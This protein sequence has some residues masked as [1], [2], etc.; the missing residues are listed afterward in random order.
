MHTR[1]PATLTFTGLFGLATAF[2]GL[3][4]T[5]DSDE[6][7]PDVIAS[8]IEQENGG[9]DMQDEAPMFGEAERFEQA[10][11][12]D[13]EEAYVDSMQADEVVVSMLELPD[14]VLFDTTVAWG[15]IPGNPANEAP[16]DWTGA[17]Q[18]NR[19]AILVRRTVLFEPND[20][21]LP[22]SDRQTVDFHSV[23]LPHRD[24]MRLTIIDPDPTSEEPLI[25][26]YLT[27]EG[28]VAAAPLASLIEEPH[29]LVADEY[30]N[31]MVAVAFARPVDLCEYGFLGGVWHR[32]APGR[33]ILLGRVVDGQGE[34][35][36]YMRGLYGRRS[37]GEQVFF[38]KYIN[39]EGEFR[40]IFRGRYGAGHFA[41]RWL[42]ASGEIGALGGEYRET[43]D[44]PETGGYFLGRWAETRCNLELPDSSEEAGE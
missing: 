25:L 20:T 11:L 15:Q 8:A 37:S 17:L 19:G 36:G 28:P 44:G 38:G 3:G 4:C 5:L 18:V 14:V 12:V 7:D 1:L 35:I 29:E 40:G 13:S 34:H 24:G 21:L 31:R 23:T 6:L 41:G 27:E 9:L 39:L 22:R 26:S 32:V 42:H 16:R 10:K 30:E 43:L 2:A 33:G